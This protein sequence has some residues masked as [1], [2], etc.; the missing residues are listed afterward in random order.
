MDPKELRS[1]FIGVTKADAEKMLSSMGFFAAS[2]FTSDDHKAYFDTDEKSHEANR[3]DLYFRPSS[4]SVDMVTGVDFTSAKERA[5]ME[6][7]PE[8]V[9]AFTI[10]QKLSAEDLFEIL[11]QSGYVKDAD[12]LKGD[13]KALAGEILTKLRRLHRYI[14]S[15]NHTLALQLVEGDMSGDDL[16]YVYNRAGEPVCKGC[17]TEA[18]AQDKLSYFKRRFPNETQGWYVSQ[19]VKEDGESEQDLPSDAGELDP[20]VQGAGERMFKIQAV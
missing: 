12:E 9:S 1:K 19:Y 20:Q 10:L 18:K 11:Y 16:W 15:R 7:D 5:M 8:H 13:G 17:P 2:R 3:I 14:E 4:H 6:D